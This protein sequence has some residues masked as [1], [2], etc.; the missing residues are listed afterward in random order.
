MAA[1]SAEWLAPRSLAEAVALRAEHGEE[2]VLV[3]GGTFV[4]VMINQRLAAPARFLALRNV[5]GLD[6]IA[7]DG[8]ELVLGAT[9]THR[10]VEDSELV[11]RG[12]PGVAEA[13]EVVATPRIRNQATVGGVVAHA[14]YASDPPTMLT[15]LGARAVLRSPGGER[16]V[17]LAEL[18]RGAYDTAIAGDELLTEIR[19]PAGA[20]RAVYRKFRSRSHEDLPC[21]GVA[22]VVA[23]GALTVTVGAACA[24]PLVLPDA[25]RLGDARA[26]GE[27]YAGAIDAISDLRG[28]AAYRRRV[29]AVEVRRAVEDVGWGT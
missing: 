7:A 16:Q 9:A 15:A 4:A 1:E 28:S 24:R 8:D 21:V 19:V 17:P 10:A 29:V 6:R 25:C 14:D 27:A 12:W 22:A 20:E 11:R 23:G 5:A 2:A 18:I 26:I 3:A 13:F